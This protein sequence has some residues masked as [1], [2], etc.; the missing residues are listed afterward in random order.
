[1]NSW[2][3]ALTE[4]FLSNISTEGD[5]HE[6]TGHTDAYGYGRYRKQGVDV[7]SHRVA[8]YLANGFWPALVRHTCDNPP[9]CKSGH[10]LDGDHASNA[11]DAVNRGQH[12]PAPR[13]F[14]E[15]VDAQI[16]QEYA[17]GG[18]SYRKLM[19]KYNTS[20]GHIQKIMGRGGED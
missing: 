20:Y 15:A 3:T 4:D 11:Q 2:P 9:C 1:M 13:K 7:K 8:F 16:R 17:A 18:T 19:T 10:L 6:W 5:C 12:V 14:D